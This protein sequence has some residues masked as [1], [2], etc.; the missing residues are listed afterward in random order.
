MFLAINDYTMFN[1][2]ASRDTNS[3]ERSRATHDGPLVYPSHGLVRICE[4]EIAYMGKTAE[5]PITYKIPVCDILGS[6]VL[7]P[8]AQQL[9]PTN[10]RSPRGVVDK[11]YAL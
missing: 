10:M 2:S 7:Q 11:R 3:G 1:K 4:I 9:Q 6:V 5:T 8:S